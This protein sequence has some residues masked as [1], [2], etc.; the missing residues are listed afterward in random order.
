M[1]SVQQLQ[2]LDFLLKRITNKSE[3]PVFQK[4]LKL[5]VEINNSYFYGDFVEMDNGYPIQDYIDDTGYVERLT[6]AL[7]GSNA[8]SFMVKIWNAYADA[9]GYG[10]TRTFFSDPLKRI[11]NGPLLFE[12][13]VKI[14]D[15]SEIQDEDSSLRPYLFNAVSLTDSVRLPF[16]NLKDKKVNL[17]SIIEAES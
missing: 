12:A 6:L 10:Q 14:L 3:Y 8:T 7:H 9:T 4:N 1:Y 11:D 13:L 2:G 16:I 5:V 15:V 17:I